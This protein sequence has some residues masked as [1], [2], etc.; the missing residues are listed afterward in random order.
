[1]NPHP[2]QHYGCRNPAAYRVKWPHRT[3]HIC[4]PHIVTVATLRD[5]TIERIKT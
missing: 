5:L 2:C 1:M 3:E 4:K